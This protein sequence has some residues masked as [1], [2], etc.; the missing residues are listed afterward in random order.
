MQKN[1]KICFKSKQILY[2]P[3]NFA[4][5]TIIDKYFMYHIRFNLIIHHK[6]DKFFLLFIYLFRLYGF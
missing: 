5:P 2:I 3:D 1:K 4:I 6:I